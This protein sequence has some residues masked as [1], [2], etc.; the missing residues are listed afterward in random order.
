MQG[1]QRQ[2]P[3]CRKKS[4]KKMNKVAA[5]VLAVAMVGSMAVPAFAKDANDYNSETDTSS[6]QKSRSTIVKYTVNSSY[7]WTIHTQVDL[8]TD[9][10][11]ANNEVHVVHNVISEGKKLKIT[12]AGQGENGEFQIKD[13]NGNGTVVRTYTVKS[14][15]GD[16]ANDDSKIAITTKVTPVLEVTSGT[17]AA[18]AKVDFAMEGV[19]S[20]N[21]ESEKA[22]NYQ[23]NVTYTADI[24][25]VND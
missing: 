10:K 12:V 20:S 2:Y 8:G 22:G 24:V 4:M 23:G 17:D 25:N 21:N 11:K 6:T 15:Q 7:E 1:A 13:N 5:A 9:G 16:S 18:F 14:N 3:H 19:N